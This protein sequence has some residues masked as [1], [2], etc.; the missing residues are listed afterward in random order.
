MKLKSYC[1]MDLHLS[2][3]VMEAQT[4]R[5]KVYF[6]RDMATETR[7][8]IEAVKAVAWG[9]AEAALWLSGANPLKVIYERLLK[10]GL[11]ESL[12]RLT[13]ARKLLSVPW[14]RWKGDAESDPALVT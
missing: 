6:H 4:A 5:G 7:C 11:K 3:T 13:V 14:G 12:A 9:A 2:H 1:A 8:L 10:K